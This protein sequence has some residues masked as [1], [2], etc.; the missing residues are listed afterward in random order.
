MVG[1]T[2]VTLLRN[3][4]AGQMKKIND[5]EIAQTHRIAKHRITASHRILPP[6]R[7]LV[8]FMCGPAWFL[9]GITF[10]VVLPVLPRPPDSP[11]LFLLLLPLLCLDLISFTSKATKL[12]LAATHGCCSTTVGEEDEGASE[13]D[14]ERQQRENRGEP[15]N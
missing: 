9:A 1:E 3:C 10:T 4:F 7:L 14:R 8:N 12:K 2:V 6:A 13:G 5:V 11:L 15:E